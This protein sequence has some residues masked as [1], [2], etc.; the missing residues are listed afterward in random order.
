MRRET[1]GRRG[2]DGEGEEQGGLVARMRARREA[3][4]FLE[5]L[6]GGGGAEEK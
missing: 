1:V 3:E 6:E 2:E 5:G 4:V